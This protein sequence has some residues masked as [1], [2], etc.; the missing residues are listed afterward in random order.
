MRRR[1]LRDRCPVRA[2]PSR[3]EGQRFRL[4]RAGDRCDLR[5]DRKVDLHTQHNA[6]STRRR[7]S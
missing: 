1:V 4:D 7:T 6:V 5:E 3:P 2:N